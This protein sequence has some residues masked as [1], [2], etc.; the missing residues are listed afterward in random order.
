[1]GRVGLLLMLAAAP[2]SAGTTLVVDV[3][4]A[5]GDAVTDAVVYAIPEG[6]VPPP[7]VRGVV[8][9]KN[10]M[11]VP[12]VLAVQTGTAV[13]FPNSDNVRHQVYSFSPAKRFQLPLYAGTPATPVVFDKPGVVAI[14][15]N[16]HDQMSAFVVVVDT[17]YFA[18]T[19]NGRAELPDLPD[20]TYAVRVWAEGMRAESPAETIRVGPGQPTRLLFRIGG[21]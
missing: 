12:H 8:D 1:M 13:S 7:S 21:K 6:K 2:A 18:R 4:D 20:G 16:I 5:R 9:Q 10:R 11:F 14:G 19:A 17:P 3:R 15:C